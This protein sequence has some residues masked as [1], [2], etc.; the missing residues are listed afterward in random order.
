MPCARWCLR[1]P[2]TVVAGVMIVAG[3][4]LSISSMRFAFDPRSIASHMTSVIIGSLF[5]PTAFLLL[6]MGK[7]KNEVPHKLKAREEKTAAP[8]AAASPVVRL[9]AR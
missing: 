3:G 1:V 6:G 4:I 9:E 5:I 8:E 2:T 7:M